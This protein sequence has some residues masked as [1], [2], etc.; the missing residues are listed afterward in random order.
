M[1]TVSHQ[2]AI[3][4]GDLQMN[5]KNEEP[6]DRNEEIVNS[7]RREFLRNSIYAAYATPIITALLVAEQSVA[8]SG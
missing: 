1:E 8:G 4:F 6:I 3:K 5:C 2:R 7:E